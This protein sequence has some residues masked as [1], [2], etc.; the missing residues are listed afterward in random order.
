MKRAIELAERG[1]G[2]VNPNPMVG[3]VLV[4]D[5]RVI[6][7]GYHE[8]YGGPH[9][10]VNAINNATENV[11]GATMYVT[12]EPCSHYGKTPPCVNAILEHQIKK[13]VIGMT[14][15]NPL[16]AGRGIE[17]LKAKGVEVVTGVLREEATK[18]NEIFIKYITTEFPF[19]IMKFAM[20][21]DGKI[22]TVTGDSKW[23]TSELSRKFVHDL[24]HQVACIMVGIGTVEKDNPYLTVRNTIGRDPVRIIVDTKARISL[25]ANVLNLDSTVK[26]IIATTKLATTDK[27][28]AIQE[29]GADII[30]TPLKNNQVDLTFLMKEIKKLGLD[31]VLLE[32]GSSLNYSALEEKLID[33]VLAFIAPKMLGGSSAKTPVGGQGIMTMDQAF[34]LEQ[35]EI[36]KLGDDLMITGTVGGRR[37]C[38]QV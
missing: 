27:L 28:K 16:V 34:K 13:V 32:G 2:F 14:D 21:L 26:T 18:L 30:M 9:A 10:E 38:L 15:P 24:R 3:A 11:A 4:K 29:K 37:E 17:L 6:G 33:K 1:L 35:L 19:V 12:L 23:I 20:T 36:L 31:S 8:Q 7:E 25:E 5:E 22:A